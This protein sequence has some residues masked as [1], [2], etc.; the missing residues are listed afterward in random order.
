MPPTTRKGA[1]SRPAEAAH[2]CMGNVAPWY[3]VGDAPRRS[4]P[5]TDFDR[6][7][8][9]YFHGSS[10]ARVK[11]L[12]AEQRPDPAEYGTRTDKGFFG[13]GFYT[14]TEPSASYGKNVLAVE[15]SLGATVLEWAA[16]IEPRF[17]YAPVSPPPWFEAMLGRLL[18]AAAQRGRSYGPGAFDGVTPGHPDFSVVMFVQEAYRYA[19]AA[20]F[21]VFQPTGG[22]TVILNPGCVER[23]YRAGKSFDDAVARFSFDAYVEAAE[24][25]ARR[26]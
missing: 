25:C 18:A 23:I 9:R 1:R 6:R 4:T 19:V 26:R 3:G 22:E 15:V 7:T 11:R 13:E 20:R 5:R 16:Q 8:R 24:R 2:D 10:P 17:G 21:D 14:T 12:L